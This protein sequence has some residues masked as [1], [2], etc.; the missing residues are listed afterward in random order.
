MP[1]KIAEIHLSNEANYLEFTSWFTGNFYKFFPSNRIYSAS[2]LLTIGAN[3]IDACYCNFLQ[4]EDDDT[5]DLI[6]ETDIN[7]LGRLG[8]STKSLTTARI[9]IGKKKPVVVFFQ[10]EPMASEWLK[11]CVWQTYNQWDDCEIIMGRWIVDELGNTDSKKAEAAKK[12][13][14]EKMTI[15]ETAK[16]YGVQNKTIALWGRIEYFLEEGLTADAIAEKVDK[17]TRTVR[18]HIQLMAEKGYHQ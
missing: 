5:V 18:H 11:K 8:V 12:R 7:P 16:Y 2:T 3:D 4:N 13:E 10:I 9:A 14:K 6:V 1:N 17:S 15:N